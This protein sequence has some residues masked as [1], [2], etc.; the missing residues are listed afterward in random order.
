MAATAQKSDFYNDLLDVVIDLPGSRQSI[1][2]APTTENIFIDDDLLSDEDIEDNSKQSIG[3]ILKDI[4]DSEV[5][6]QYKLTT[7][8]TTTKTTTTIKKELEILNFKDIFLPK[9]KKKILLLLPTS[10]VIHKKYKKIRQK[11]NDH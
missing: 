11:K 9:R 1:H 7:T 6:M 8:T 2:D 4:N 3:N 10:E 5:L